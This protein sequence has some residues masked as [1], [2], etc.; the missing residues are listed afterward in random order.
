[1]EIADFNTDGLPDFYLRTQNS[2]STVPGSSFVLLGELSSPA[3]IAKVTLQSDLV[4]NITTS[5]SGSTAYTAST[6]PSSPI[7]TFPNV[8]AKLRITGSG[9]IYSRVTN[10]FSNTVTVT[11]TSSSAIAGPLQVGFT[12]LS[13]GV[14]L[15]NPTSKV[16]EGFIAIPS[17]LAAGQSASIAVRFSNPFNSVISYKTVAYTGVF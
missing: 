9:F 17:G 16:G 14:T 15:A 2:G 5:Y 3:S 4:H 12:N 8:T 7:I 11:N 6:S 13:P 1:M 10:T